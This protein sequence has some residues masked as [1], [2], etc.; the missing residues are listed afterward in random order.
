VRFVHAVVAMVVAGLAVSVL[1]APA[2]A[3]ASASSEPAV[4]R[5]GACL[6]SHGSG[7]LLLLI[8]QSGSLKQTDPGGVRV[9]AAQYLLQQLSQTAKA[10]DLQVAVAGFDDSYHRTVPWQKLSSGTLPSLDRS[11]RAYANR[12]TGFETDYAN[13]LAGVRDE[14]R[15][16]SRG[17]QRCQ[18]VLWFTDGQFS[19]SP[20]LNSTDRK[21][22]GTTKQYAPGVSLTD[23]AGAKKAATLGR[24]AM[25]RPGGTI[26]QIRISGVITLAVGL[27]PNSGDFSLMQALATGAGNCGSPP[28]TP[29]GVFRLAT[30]VDD[31]LFALDAFSDPAHPP[32]VNTTLVCQRNACDKQAHNFV[33]DLSIRSVHI[34][35]EADK[36]GIQIL[37]R[38]PNN[39]KPAAFTY[40]RTGPLPVI[41]LDGQSVKAAWITDK[42]L[43]LTLDRT[44]VNSWP[45]QW[46][47]VFVDRS[48]TSPTARARTAIH[49]TG[50][51][52][53]N[54][55]DPSK[56]TL[57]SNSTATVLIGLSSE[58][59]LKAVAPSQVLGVARV[60]ATLRAADGKIVPIVAGAA[61]GALAAGFPVDLKGVSPGSAV[62]SLQLAVTTKGIAASGG[63]AAIP[64]TQL[65]DRLIEA[66]VK[67]LPPLNFPSVPSQMDFGH[68]TGT[69][70]LH[71]SLPVTGP[72]CVWITGAQINASPEGVGKVTAV[73]DSATS[74]ST[75]LKVAKGQTRRLPV[76]LSIANAGTGTLG[77]TVVAHLAPA[78]APEQAVTSPVSFLGDVRKPANAEVLWLTFAIAL[79]I[80]LCLPI[81][82]LYAL[83]AWTARIPGIALLV[84]IVPVEVTDEGVT[85]GGAGFAVSLEEL[86][87]FDL[88]SSTRDLTPVPGVSLRTRTPLN[89]LNAGFTQVTASGKVVATSQGNDRLPLAIHG[90]WVALLT[91]PQRR[92]VSLLMLMPAN[93]TP[94]QIANASEEIRNNLPRMVASLRAE[95]AAAGFAPTP[96]ATGAGGFAMGPAVLPPAGSGF[97]D[98]FGAPPTASSPTPP[99][100]PPSAQPPAPTQQPPA[101]PDE[102]PRQPGAEGSWW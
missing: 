18:A 64:G 72:G 74:P 94:Q 34:L 36:G 86:Q 85:R 15:S 71:A 39:A 87:F 97:G 19:I 82:F 84:G 73:A 25:C 81:A 66:P 26:D 50:D 79:L 20:R 78:D 76:T 32:T 45:G 93:A 10:T 101:E 77:G 68:V 62:I 83:R 65:A 51:L 2:S 28:T 57:R 12:N 27:G 41:T 33:L 98:G 7:D 89:P 59:T 1:G 49:I 13:A 58:A 56:L 91:E 92:E 4:Q 52:V 35:A 42:T 9:K 29:V 37:L 88:P 99:Y 69:V 30:D 46:S 14:L 96:V 17:G 38:P 44:S 47:I 54:L 80:G 53:P 8:D 22:Y 61:P 31:L 48:G 21:T 60:S 11:L 24:R 67:V 90:S 3:G 55:V 40:A 43:D 6:A 102:P 5:L 70:P 95:A 75:C 16:R 63:R 100:S 23:A